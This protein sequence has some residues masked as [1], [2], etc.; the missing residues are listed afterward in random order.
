MVRRLLVGE[1]ER[2]EISRIGWF[3]RDLLSRQRLG[4]AANGIVM[5]VSMSAFDWWY[6]RFDRTRI[7]NCVTALRTPIRLAQSHDEVAPNN[8]AMPR[9][10]GSTRN[11]SRM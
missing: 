11:V 3:D 6:F 7:E 1:R 8:T 2:A 5:L 10:R 9:S 4:A